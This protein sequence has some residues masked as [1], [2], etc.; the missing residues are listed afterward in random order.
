[1]VSGKAVSTGSFQFFQAECLSAERE[2]EKGR[3]RD[4]TR[5]RWRE[6][7]GER[8][9]KSQPLLERENKELGMSECCD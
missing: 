9:Y 6:N 5:A 2:A 8:S 3:K 7:K 1:M 4:V